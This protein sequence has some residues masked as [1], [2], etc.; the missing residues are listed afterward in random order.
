[1]VRPV[2]KL[3]P[4]ALF[5]FQNKTLETDIQN[6]VQQ[7]YKISGFGRVVRFPEQKALCDAKNLG[8]L[9]PMDINKM[10]AELRQE[11]EQI[12]EAIMTLERL[13]RGRGRRRGRPPAWMTEIK[14]RGRPPGSKNKPKPE[15]KATSSKIAVA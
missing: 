5:C 9:K 12:E 7:L 15:A 1:M 11:R 13:A 2:P 3:S 6:A 4:L 10:L 14:R 8:R